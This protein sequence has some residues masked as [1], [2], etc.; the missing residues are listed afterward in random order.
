MPDPAIRRPHEPPVEPPLVAGWI[1]DAAVFELRG[2]PEDAGVVAAVRDATGLALPTTPGTSRA[3]G[4]RRLVWVGPDHWYAVMPAADS[5]E[6]IARL[7]ADL[8][9]RRHALVDLSSALLLLRLDG[10][11]SRAAL[12]QGCPLDLDP[13]AFPAHAAAGSVYFKASVS[14][15]RAD[16]R[17]AFDLLVRRSFANYVWEMIERSCHERGLTRQRWLMAR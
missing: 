10:A 6:P 4:G 11:A 7:H 2:D 14:L 9:T 1:D 13:L 16:D 8:A 15:W 12:A 17:N 5:A 3:G